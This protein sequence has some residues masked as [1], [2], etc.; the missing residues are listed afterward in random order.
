[1]LPVQN[2]WVKDHKQIYLI[3]NPLVWYLS[4]WSLLVYLVVRGLLLL[5]AQRGYRDF[6]NSRYSLFASQTK[7]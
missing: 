1:M 5:R 7:C 2:F 6:E 3:G 4:T